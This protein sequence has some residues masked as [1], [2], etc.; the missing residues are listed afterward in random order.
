MWTHLEWNK[1]KILVRKVNPEQVEPKTPTCC[2]LQFMKSSPTPIKD[3]V[4]LLCA[5]EWVCAGFLQWN[6]SQ[7]T[8]K[9][10]GQPSDPSGKRGSTV[11]NRH[12]SILHPCPILVNISSW[13]SSINEF[14]IRLSPRNG[15]A[16][17]RWWLRLTRTTQADG[18]ARIH[19][20]GC[21]L[22]HASQSS[23]T[24]RG[25]PPV[26]RLFLN[27]WAELCRRRTKPVLMRDE[28]RPIGTE[29]V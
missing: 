17:Q 21:E 13:S 27:F 18:A 29:S 9:Q 14:M 22:H 23:V 28:K 15:S 12:L 5:L 2:W 25:F 19:I 7:K 16:G 11:N 24:D 1:S 20:W 6:I 4:C 8:I 10:P 26:L 3:S